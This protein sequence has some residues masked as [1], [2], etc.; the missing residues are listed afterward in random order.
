MCTWSKRP[1]TGEAGGGWRRGLGPCVRRRG[2]AHGAG[3][4]EDRG[5]DVPG[6]SGWGCWE[7]IRAGSRSRRGWERPPRTGKLPEKTEREPGAGPG[8]S[9]RLRNREPP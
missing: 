1:V 7:A 6:V 9:E 5:R 8:C 4:A 2:D 3:L